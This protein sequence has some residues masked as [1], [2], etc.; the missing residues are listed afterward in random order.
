MSEVS[1]SLS[2]EQRAR[3][4][5][6]LYE[7]IAKVWPAGIH[8]STSDPDVV[9]PGEVLHQAIVDATARWDAIEVRRD[10]GDSPYFTRFAVWTPWE[11]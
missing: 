2:E 3:F 7:S 10:E 1:L 11:K 8:S 6:F 4:Q 9:W 5:E